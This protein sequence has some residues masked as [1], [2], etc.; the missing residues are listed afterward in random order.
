MPLEESTHLGDHEVEEFFLALCIYRLE[1]IEFSVWSILAG[2]LTDSLREEVSTDDDTLERRSSLK[3]GILHIS[4]AV[5]EDGTEEFLLGSRIGLTLRSDLTDH[6]ITGHDISTDADDTALI[7]VLGS[8]LADIGDIGSKFL[9]AALG[10]ADIEAIFIDM[11]RS[12]DI[13]ADHTLIEHDSILI[14]IT[15]PGHESHLEVSTQ[16]EFTIFGRIA[17][18]EDVT[19][20]DTLAL[21]ADRTEVDSGALVGAAE[22]RYSIFLESR[23]ELNEL[24]ILG[25]IVED[26][27]GSGVDKVD[28]TGAFSHDLCTRI[29]DK[30]PL[31]TGTDD[32]SLTAEQRHSLAH[33]V[34]TH[35]CTVGVVMLEEGDQ[36]RGDRCDLDRS[37][38]HKLHFRGGS[39][40]EVGVKTSLDTRI[41]E[42]AII[43]DR[44]IT[45]GD[46]LTLFDFG[47]EVLDMRII[48]ID[49]AIIYLAI[50]GFDETEVIDFCVNAE[51]RNQT[52]VRTF[53][54]LDWAETAIMSIV[55]VTDLETGTFTR[56]T[57]GA[58]SRHTA[59]VSDLGEGVGLIH[60]L[61]KGIRTEE[62]IDCSRDSLGID[63]IDRFE[64]LIIA[65]IHFLADGAS[66]TSQT[67]GEL[68]VE[69]LADGADATVAKVVD[70][71]D[72][73]FGIDQ[74]DKILDDLDD[75]LLGEDFDIDRS[76]ET[77]FLIDTV[78]T[79]F[80]EVIT[81]LAEE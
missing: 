71:I 69:L 8:I 18:G 72:I 66:H 22:F 68:V 16:G 10:V 35:E 29:A 38:I 2:L 64:H 42:R 51:R 43:I 32:R 80:A 1:F 76:I 55:H 27:D 81:L 37:H 41:H 19:L 56:Q 67:D 44:S 58:E 63:Q 30:L 54:G 14:V 40:R 20:I 59:L 4:G 39:D 46:D 79:D 25:S 3:R 17:F 57:A 5:A 7:E 75:I 65:D 62:G 34:R 15:L 24:L 61:R 49:H 77:E 26:T 12:E 73:T 45:L 6:D 13:L 74:L 48:E 33:H 70:I 53:R 60:E 36:R 47:G 78:T 52:D 11:D 31:D 23:F 21:I 9:L 28:N 50:R